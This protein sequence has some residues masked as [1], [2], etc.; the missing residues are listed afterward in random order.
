MSGGQKAPKVSVV[1]SVYNDAVYLGEAIESILNQTFTDFEFL[2]IN[3]GSTDGSRAV[4]LFYADPRVRLVD[5][6]VNLGL[7]ASLNKGIRLAKGEYI[8]RQDADDVSLPDRLAQQVAFLD[9][10]S[11]VTVVG[12]WWEHIDVDGDVFATGEIPNSNTIIKAK[13]IPNILKFPHGCIMIHREAL[14]RI[15]GYDGR[16]RFTQDL[17]VWLRMV[18]EGYRFGAV[19]RYLYQLRMKV[20]PNDFKQRCQSRYRALAYERFF[21]DQELDVPD[22]LK[23]V[24]EEVDGNSPSRDSRLHST[25]WYAIGMRAHVDRRYRQV[26]KCLRKSFLTGDPLTSLKF[27]VRLALNTGRSVFTKASHESN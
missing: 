17:D 2:I 19:E 18:K 3:D 25:Y 4:I 11:D 1:M 14:V 27:V 13:L 24:Q 12:C 10:H 23:E 8:A 22:V 20:E 26:L 9:A 6:E 16:F 7:P 21:S 15:G 5:N